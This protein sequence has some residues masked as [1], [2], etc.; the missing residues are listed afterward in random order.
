MFKIN[1][2]LMRMTL[3]CDFYRIVAYLRHGSCGGN[4]VPIGSSLPNGDSP[5]KLLKG[6][7][8]R[9]NGDTPLPTKNK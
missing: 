7:P 1:I 3:M 2:W 9:P 8:Y 4:G 5:G 6:E